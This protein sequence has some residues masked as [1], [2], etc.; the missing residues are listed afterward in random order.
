VCVCV[1]VCG[2]QTGG[3]GHDPDAAVVMEKANQSGASYRSCQNI[4]RPDKGWQ[5]KREE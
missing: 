3:M 2:S 4:G 5:G 1:C